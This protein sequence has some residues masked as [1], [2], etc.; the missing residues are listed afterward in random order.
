MPKKVP[1]RG[2]CKTLDHQ[3]KQL[4]VLREKVS[5]QNNEIQRLRAE[6]KKQ[7]GGE[8]QKILTTNDLL[9][10]E[11]SLQR[12]ELQA[13]RAENKKLRDAGSR[14]K[15]RYHKMREQYREANEKLEFFTSQFGALCKSLEDD[16]YEAAVDEDLAAINAALASDAECPICNED[17]VTGHVACCKQN[18]CRACF[19]K[20]SALQPT[21]P[22]C[23]ADDPKFCGL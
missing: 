17:L 13:L 6:C 14:C 20:V 11:N 9:K 12:E 18:I 2:A 5:A 4:S 21:C 23:R 3:R 16:A 10:R 22:F 7:V 1:G 19:D 8:I 15:H